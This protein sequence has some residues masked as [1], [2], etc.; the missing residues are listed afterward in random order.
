MPAAAVIAGMAAA[1]EVGRHDP[2]LVAV[3][4]TSPP[5]T[6]GSVPALPTALAAALP[7]AAR[8]AEDRLPPTLLGYDDLLNDDLPTGATA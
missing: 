3:D 6:T 1:L 8:A 2:D 5:P 4:A 7:P